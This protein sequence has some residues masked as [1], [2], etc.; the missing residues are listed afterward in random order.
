MAITGI[1]LHHLRCFV[2][3]AEERHF[4]RAADRLALSQPT[5][6]RTIRRLEEL[7]GYR[8]L[9]RTTRQVTL[10]AA[11]E[12]LY[13]ELRV[14]LPRLTAA[15]RPAPDAPL[16]RIGF[17][18]GFPAT[19]PQAAI[20]RFEAETGVGARV[21]RRDAA[22]AGVDSGEVD[23]AI[24]RGRVTAP[25]MTAVTLL[26]ER[27]IAAVSVRSELAARDEISWRELA[28]RRLVLNQ[29]SGTTDPSDWPA[30]ERPEVAVRCGNFDEW[31]EAV[32][33]NRGIGVVPESIGR[34]RVH[35]FVSFVAIPDAPLLPLRLV[36]PRN[37]EHPLTRRFLAHARATV[38]QCE[39][40]R[41]SGSESGNGHGSASGGAGGDGRAGGGVGV[42]EPVDAPVAEPGA[43]RATDADAEAGAHL[44][45]PRP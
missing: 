43:G 20:E 38:R 30:D 8:V 17:A 33:G 28:G 24:L 21:F 45:G 2:A 35:P 9:E 27:R 6:S 44:A 23:I 26:H 12:R 15:L 34:Q 39:G 36:Y 16:F 1:E 40:G 19:W 37:D 41:G 3:L 10:T 7:L 18:W 29:V 25:G 32:A 4:T 31:L 42:P 13:D 5:V 14:L 22:L 11:G